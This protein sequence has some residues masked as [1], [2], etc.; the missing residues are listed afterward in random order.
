MFSLSAPSDS[1]RP[2]FSL[3]KQES[4]L[5][6]LPAALLEEQWFQLYRVL[7]VCF[8]H[9]AVTSEG[10]RGP[11]EGSVVKYGVKPDCSLHPHPLTPA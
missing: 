3:G 11:L 9:T 5:P 4:A 7:H 1:N 6:H 10:A 8:R 2:A